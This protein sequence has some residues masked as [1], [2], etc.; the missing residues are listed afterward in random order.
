M[1][2]GDFIAARHEEL[3]AWGKYV[4]KTV[5]P[6]VRA[7]LKV[8][9]S[10]RVKGTVSAQAK[11][12]RKG[13]TYPECDMNDLVGARFVVLTSNDLEPVQRIILN[14]EAWTC[15]ATR[16]PVFESIQDPNSFVYQSHH[17]E[18]RPRAPMFLG[19]TTVQPDICCEVQIRTLLQH[20]YAELTHDTFY[21]PDQT[22]P[23]HAERLVARSMALMETTDELLCRALEAVTKANQPVT[24]LASR[25]REIASSVDQPEANRLIRMIACE[26]PELVSPGASEELRDL[27]ARRPYVL[28]RIRERHGTGLFDFP[29]AALVGYWVA[30]RLETEALPRWP[31]A[32]SHTEFNQMLT[33]LG[34]ASPTH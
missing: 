31:L 4:V 1:D 11:Q 27:T 20:A 2:I 22:I 33:D 8:P 25:A 5:R 26:F 24:D 9:A 14:H 3:K 34:V 32:G 7:L 6:H 15:K 19:E 12:V 29:A 18:V 16:D 30:D 17:Y 28:D 21:K 23:S 13:Y 10:F